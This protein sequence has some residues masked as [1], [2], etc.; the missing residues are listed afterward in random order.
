MGYEQNLDKT[1]FNFSVEQYNTSRQ[2]P[3]AKGCNG[4]VATNLGDT[5]VTVNDQVLFPSATPATVAGDSV[6]NMGNQG[7]IYTASKI[8]IKFAS[9]GGAAPLVEIQQKYYLENTF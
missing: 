5:I 4:Y 9:P 2:I 1:R 8:V 6:S 3:V 7:E